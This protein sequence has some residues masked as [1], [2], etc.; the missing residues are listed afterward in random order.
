[1]IIITVKR[2]EPK[3]P[4]WVN[5]CTR[6]IVPV[7]VVLR[8]TVVGCDWHFDNLCG[9]H[10]QS[11]IHSLTLKPRGVLNLSLGREVPPGPWNPDPLYDFQVKFHSFFSSKNV[12][13]RPQS[14]NQSEGLNLN[15]KPLYRSGSQ[16][17]AERRW[18][19]V[20]SNDLVLIWLFNNQNACMW[21]GTYRATWR[22]EN[23]GDSGRF[24]ARRARSLAWPG[25]S[26][27]V[28]CQPFLRLCGPS[29]F[30]IFSLENSSNR[31]Q[32]AHKRQA[33]GEFKV[34]QLYFH[35]FRFLFFGKKYKT[36]YGK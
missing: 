31:A 34:G 17:L 13:F 9:S 3:L 32:N 14:T 11:Q 21:S 1:M 15:R 4:K 24:F 23:Y 8:R 30:Q 2:Y 27:R 36:L 19:S 5:V 16:A 28:G 26:W 7:G 29:H 20:Y 33:Q 35:L 22:C 6:L 18:A 10:L 25:V 12:T